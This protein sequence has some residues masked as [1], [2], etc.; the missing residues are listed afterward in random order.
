MKSTFKSHCSHRTLSHQCQNL[1]ESP[2]INWW[3]FHIQT[4]TA[5]SDIGGTMGVFCIAEKLGE[6]L[7]I[8]HT[9]WEYLKTLGFSIGS[10]HFGPRSR[11]GRASCHPCHQ[12]PL[13]RPCAPWLSKLRDRRSSFPSHRH[14]SGRTTRWS[15]EG[16]LK[17]C[18]LFFGWSMLV[19]CDVATCRFAAGRH[20]TPI[21]A[22]RLA[23]PSQ[24]PHLLPFTG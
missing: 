17:S 4:W 15:C 12:Q 21:I 13:A 3:S 23:P 5:T 19:L 11:G 1:T 2:G 18:D 6:S 22:P 10:I 20:F 9:R 14:G 24:T 7:P 16:Y 8:L